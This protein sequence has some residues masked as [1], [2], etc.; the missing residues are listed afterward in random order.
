LSTGLPRDGPLAFF[1]R[2]GVLQ[3]LDDHGEVSMSKP[4]ASHLTAS[5]LALAMP[6]AC[7]QNYQETQRQYEEQRR[8]LQAER[9]EA[10][11]REEAQRA[12]D[13]VDD[14]ARRDHERDMQRSR[15]TSQESSGNFN[16][17]GAVFTLGMLAALA[18]SFQEGRGPRQSYRTRAPSP[19]EL[20]RVARIQ[21]QA[22][23]MHQC[24]K[25]RRTELQAPK[26][27]APNSWAVV[28]LFQPDPRKAY[29]EAMQ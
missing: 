27:E 19:E 22:F 6:L 26:Y 17:M 28:R 21:R 29:Q 24:V 2:T 11:R 8:A 10:R 3:P 1:E 16:L 14:L 7:A 5:A 4:W 25:V 12:Q 20:A 9:E 15:S 23:V 13:L 18:E